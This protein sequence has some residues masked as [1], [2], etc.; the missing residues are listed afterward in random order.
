MPSPFGTVF[1]HLYALMTVSLVLGLSSRLLCSQSGPMYVPLIPGFPRII[2]SLLTYLRQNHSDQ[3]DMITPIGS[4]HNG[5]QTG[6]WTRR[7]ITFVGPQVAGTKTSETRKPSSRKG[8]LGA[9][10]TVSTHRG[11]HVFDRQLQYI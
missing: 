9:M 5:E 4:T 11:Y 6:Y 1:P 8:K 7:D 3:P 10:P 2:N